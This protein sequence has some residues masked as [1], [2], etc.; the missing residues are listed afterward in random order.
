MSCVKGMPFSPRKADFKLIGALLIMFYDH[1][2]KSIQLY[3]GHLCTLHSCVAYSQR[4]HNSSRQQSDL[5][6][7]AHL[8]VNKIRRRQV[9]Y[10]DIRSKELWKKKKHKEMI[11]CLKLAAPNACTLLRGC[12][13]VALMQFGIQ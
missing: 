11:E 6:T 13:S 10:F 7:G 3:S 5:G 4:L 9:Q 8:K 12:D 1:S 2:T